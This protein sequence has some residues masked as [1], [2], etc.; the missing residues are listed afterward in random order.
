[1]YPRPVARLVWCAPLSERGWVQHMGS[2]IRQS[3]SVPVHVM[4]YI[5]HES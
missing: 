5:L 4:S 2:M 1:M 3:R